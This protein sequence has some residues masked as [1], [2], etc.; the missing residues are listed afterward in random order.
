MRLIVSRRLSV[1][2][3]VQRPRKAEPRP[4]TSAIGAWCSCPSP[5]YPRRSL[6]PL[7]PRTRLP[8]PAQDGRA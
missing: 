2:K 5:P 7:A 8:F 3:G 1:A 4:S 6:S